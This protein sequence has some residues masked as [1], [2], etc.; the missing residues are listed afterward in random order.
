MDAVIRRFYAPQLMVL[1]IGSVFTTGPLEAAYVA[2][3]LVKPKAVIASYLSF[4]PVL[5]SMVKG[6]RSPDA[7]QLDQMR[8]WNASAAQDFWKL[9]L[10]ASLPYFFASLKVAIAAA[11]MTV[12][13]IYPLVYA[14]WLSLYK[15]NAATRKMV[16]DPD[17]NWTKLFFDDRVWGALVNTFV[18]TGIALVFQ[19]VLGMMISMLAV[20]FMPS[21]AL[22]LP[23]YLGWVS[24]ETTIS[25]E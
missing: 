23:A 6:L 25:K 1:N 10:P 13:G 24:S 7:M 5:V 9:R 17:H 14:L 11:L 19:L 16:F 21:L 8:T 22:W 12:F 4:F 15:R 20:L 2:N 18:Y 3:E